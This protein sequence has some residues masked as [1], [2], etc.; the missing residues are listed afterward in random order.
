MLGRDL[1]GGVA[2]AA[3]GFAG[4]DQADEIEVV[5]PATPGVGQRW[6]SRH[7]SAIPIGPMPRPV[8][9]AVGVVSWIAHLKAAVAGSI[10]HSNAVFLGTVFPDIVSRT[11]ET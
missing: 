2:R 8:D 7:D 4:G 9:D 6:S 1:K 11:A 5:A 3:E 10:G